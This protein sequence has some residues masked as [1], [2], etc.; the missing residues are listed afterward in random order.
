MRIAW[1]VCLAI[2]VGLLV[3]WLMRQCEQSIQVGEERVPLVGGAL[4]P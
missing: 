2:V 4:E 1:H 3:M